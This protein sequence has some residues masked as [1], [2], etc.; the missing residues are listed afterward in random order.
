MRSATAQARVPNVRE[1]EPRES[2]RKAPRVDQHGEVVYFLDVDARRWRVYDTSTGATGLPTGL[3]VHRLGSPS[4][5]ERVFVPPDPSA[6]RFVYTFAAGD[7]RDV[8]IE[9]LFRQLVA[10]R[11]MPRPADSCRDPRMRARLRRIAM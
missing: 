11:V 8:T 3:T 1:H 6:P 10:A 7:R 2:S 9:S 5:S 4:A